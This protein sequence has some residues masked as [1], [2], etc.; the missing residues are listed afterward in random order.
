MAPTDPSPTFSPAQRR[1]LAFSVTLAAFALGAALVVGGAWGL[2][3]LIGF[4]SGVL[5]P[6]AVA[7]I[8][9]LI[10]RPLVDR[11]ET[12]FG[13]RRT[14][15]VTVL[16]A[17]FVAAVVGVALLIV[18]R[19]VRQILD[20]IAFTPELYDRARVYVQE[21][22]PDWIA[23]SERLRSH[24]IV[25]QAWTAAQKQLAE[26]PALILP[27]LKAIGEG[28]FT[29]ANFVTQLAIIPIYL[30]FFLLFRG[31]PTRGLPAHLP[32]LSPQLRDDVVFLV[33]EFVSLVVSFFRGQILIGLV[34]GIL[35]ALGFTIAGLK[36]GLL[37]GLFVGLLN[38]IPY[39]GTIIGLVICIPMAFFQ[40][41]GGLGLV[42]TVL[43]IKV[44]VQNIEGWILTPR[45]MGERTGLHP[46][47]II[48]A[49][50][51]WGRAFGGLLG[52]ILAIPLTA[53]FVTAWRWVRH[54][55]FDQPAERS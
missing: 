7:G 13:G 21:H 27:S 52:M 24:A 39:L 25:E 4:F 44:A 5:W 50:F 54:R 9:A 48:V 32:F 12:A 33:G 23:L 20:L 17:C 41:D 2:G 34:M 42:I 6:L 47:A 31:E 55:Y 3:I 10:L 8:L 45:I 30:F 37:L 28:A 35:Y 38:I 29:A 1:T 14:V 40:P 26:V 51:F 46:V 22:Y 36:F 43:A 53:F 15:A 11:L 16:Y 49:I 18:P 19:L